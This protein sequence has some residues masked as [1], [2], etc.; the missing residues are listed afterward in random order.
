MTY[1]RV[2]KTPGGESYEFPISVNPYDFSLFNARN[3]DSDNAILAV[4][5]GMDA[6]REAVLPSPRF[7]RCTVPDVPTDL[8]QY[9]VDAY[10]LSCH[11]FDVG[12]HKS[13][14]AARVSLSPRLYFMRQVTFE[15]GR[16]VDVDENVL[17]VLGV[18]REAEAACD[19][20]QSN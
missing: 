15:D 3:F 14:R 8:P 2:H 16:K 20:S 18:Y 17:R 5:G 19:E 12:P 7:V 10:H 11:G 6:C 4:T 13:S 1:Y 9:F